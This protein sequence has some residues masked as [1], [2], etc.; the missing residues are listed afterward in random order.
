[1]HLLDHLGGVYKSVNEAGYR[2]MTAQ[3]RR[4]IAAPLM[5]RMRNSNA[6]LVKI[7]HKPE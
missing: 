5:S 2:Q 6:N 4:T 1:V 7:A 3:I